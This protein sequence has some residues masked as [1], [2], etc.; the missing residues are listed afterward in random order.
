MTTNQDHNDAPEK[1]IQIFVNSRP[2]KVEGPRI[3]FEAVLALAGFQATPGE[4]DLYDVQWVRG[5]EAGTLTKGLD[6]E[7][8]NGMRFDVGKSNRS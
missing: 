3:T 6:V 1:T 7:V 5:N 4:L 2:R 8:L